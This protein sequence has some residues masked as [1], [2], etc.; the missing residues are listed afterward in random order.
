[1]FA[2]ERSFTVHAKDTAGRLVPRLVERVVWNGRKPVF[3]LTTELGKTITATGNHPFWTLDGWKNL[4]DLRVGDRIAAARVLRVPT[5]KRW[6]KH[7][8]ITLAGLLSE[9]NTCHPSCLYFFNNDADLL[10]DFA[11]AIERFPQTVARIDP[12]GDGRWQVSAST[13][14]GT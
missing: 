9:G 14:R 8:L 10:A 1:L 7:R 4:E 12:R 5:K 13:G 11:Q 3:R 2:E 6:P